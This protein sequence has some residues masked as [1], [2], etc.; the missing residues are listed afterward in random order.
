MKYFPIKQIALCANKLGS[1]FSAIKSRWSQYDYINL[2]NESSDEGSLKDDEAGDELAG[3]SSAS[4]SCESDDENSGNYGDTDPSGGE[5]FDR[6]TDFAVKYKFWDNADDGKCGLLTHSSFYMLHEM[7][8]K[9]M[10]NAREC[11][12][13]TNKCFIACPAAFKIQ[14]SGFIHKI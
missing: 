12:A 1:A 11:G 8:P 2:G 6:D 9:C 13:R 14:W 10:K 5:S 4:T 7:R 3:N